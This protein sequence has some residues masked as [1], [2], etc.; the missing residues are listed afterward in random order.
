MEKGRK[1]QKEKIERKKN[2]LNMPFT[3]IVRHYMEIKIN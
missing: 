1:S 2:E 3:Y